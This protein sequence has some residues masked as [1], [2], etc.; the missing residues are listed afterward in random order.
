MQRASKTVQG[1]LLSFYLPSSSPWTTRPGKQKLTPYYLAKSFHLDFRWTPPTYR[2]PPYPK[3]F[4]IV[5]LSVPEQP[6]TGPEQKR[7]GVLGA[8]GG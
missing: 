2:A 4:P 7:R 8:A 5:L 3:P 1:H 6:L